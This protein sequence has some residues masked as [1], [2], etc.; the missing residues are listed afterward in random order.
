MSQESQGVIER[1]ER[2]EI[3]PPSWLILLRPIGTEEFPDSIGV[4]ELIYGAFPAF[5]KFKNALE[6]MHISETNQNFIHEAL[7]NL[8]EMKSEGRRVIKDVVTLGHVRKLNTSKLNEIDGLKEEG[9]VGI[10][11]VRKLFSLS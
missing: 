7:F 3:P 1:R 8:V 11:I 2:K 4:H 5:Y 10:S 6:E 9:S